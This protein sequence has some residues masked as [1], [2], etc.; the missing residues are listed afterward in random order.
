MILKIQKSKIMIIIKIIIKIHQI[1]ISKVLKIMQVKK[2][3]NKKVSNHFN[4]KVKVQVK[5]LI[6]EIK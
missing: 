2:K 5:K 4:K 3:I 6:Q 1:K